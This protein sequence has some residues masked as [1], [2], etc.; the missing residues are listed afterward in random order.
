MKTH[1]E[2]G[3]VEP[4]PTCRG[5]A[6][7]AAGVFTR[8]RGLRRGISGNRSAQHPLRLQ[9]QHL[10]ALVPVGDRFYILARIVASDRAGFGE[11][12]DQ[13]LL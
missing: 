11:A 2:R 9:R 7:S 8:N 6:L 5:V 10:E 3:V 13:R 12:F 1:S 4:E